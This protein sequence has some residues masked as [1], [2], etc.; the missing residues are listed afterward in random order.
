MNY[1]LYDADTMFLMRAP[2]STIKRILNLR[3]EAIRRIEDETIGNSVCKVHFNGKTNP[4]A[5]GAF[6]MVQKAVGSR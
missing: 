2:M 6:V 1:D 4:V 3:P 5:N